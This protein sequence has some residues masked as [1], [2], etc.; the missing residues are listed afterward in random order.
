[1]KKA[2]GLVAFLVF[3]TPFGLI[4][5][6]DWTRIVEPVPT[7]QIGDTWGDSEDYTFSR[8]WGVSV[9]GDSILVLDGDPNE[10]RVFNHKGE[11]LGRM[12]GDGEG[13]GEF[14]W[15]T[16]IRTTPEGIV[17]SDPRL[18]RQTFFSYSGEVLRTEPLGKASDVPFSDAAKLRGGQTIGV[19]SVMISNQI[20][21]HPDRTLVL[22]D[23][24]T[25][26]LDTIA[27]YF[28]GV[29]P[30]ISEG[31]YGFLRP[32]TGSEG[33]WVVVGDSLV[34]VVSGQPP[35]LQWWK[36]E[37]E[38][39]SMQGELEI[40]VQP[41]AFTRR[42]EQALLEEERKLREEAGARPLPR[43]G[44]VGS[45]DYWGQIGSVVASTGNECWIQW[46]QPRTEDDQRWFRVD[47]ATKE[48]SQVELPAGFRLSSATGTH[49]YG[50][51]RTEL[52]VPMVTVFR[53][54]NGG[55]H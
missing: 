19:T 46:D 31:S 10:I 43:N 21:T 8:I 54:A 23:P 26:R 49:L 17:V 45:P 6:T 11:F 20:G 52:D 33:D 5:Q 1:M 50:V 27:T 38:S 2:C 41:Q 13:P 42:D 14:R 36:S 28:Q 53:L 3:L 47:L 18:R 55:K 4:A 51:M 15:A 12:G 9:V 7:L 16:G 40:P 48:I 24:R 30:F 44:E 35:V 34:V 32:S 22:L 39:L 29:V 25:E 37:A